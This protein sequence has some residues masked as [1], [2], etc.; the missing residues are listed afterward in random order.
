MASIQNFYDPYQ[1]KSKVDRKLLHDKGMD[2][3][4]NKLD[5]ILLNKTV[6]IDN[7]SSFNQLS[8]TW[9]KNSTQ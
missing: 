1:N 5:E 2:K 8:Q 7:P 3:Y 6:S 9:R 4:H